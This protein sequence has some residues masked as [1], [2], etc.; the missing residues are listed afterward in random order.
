MVAVVA[1]LPVVVFL[2][3]LPQVVHDFVLVTN[4]ELR[5]HNQ[6]ISAVV[7]QIRASKALRT[8]RLMTSMQMKMHKEEKV[9]KAREEEE[10]KNS[11]FF[12]VTI[13]AGGTAHNKTLPVTE[14]KAELKAKR[15][16]RRDEL[17][18][19]FS[20]FDFNGDG[21]VG[22]SEIKQ[23]L[24]Q[25]GFSDPH[26]ADGIVAEIDADKSGSITFDEFFEWMMQVGYK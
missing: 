25:L 19:M 1:V 10:K 16:A 8:L 22:H 17:L 3:V 6:E 4:V 21:D 26:M 24:D 14:S 18:E 15:A 23:L 9:R 7:R 13:S 5:K 11:W 20:L 12:G 2:G